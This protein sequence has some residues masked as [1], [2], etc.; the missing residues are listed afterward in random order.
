MC[1]NWTLL[2][3]GW[4]AKAPPPKYLN[5]TW[6]KSFAANIQGL[7]YF[8]LHFGNLQLAEHWTIHRKEEIVHGALVFRKKKGKSLELWSYVYSTR[9]ENI[10]LSLDWIEMM[11]IVTHP[12]CMF[13]VT[14]HMGIVHVCNL[15]CAMQVFM[16]LR[17][18]SSLWQ[19]CDV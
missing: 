17:G 13:V 19:E 12:I 16:V 3:I 11:R 4:V 9:H 18:Q 15:F 14:I 7:W 8:K 5:R 10:L 1:N 6:T 2:R